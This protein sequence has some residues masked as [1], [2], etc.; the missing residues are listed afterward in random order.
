MTT[1]K[2]SALINACGWVFFLVAAPWLLYKTITISGSSQ[3]LWA[4][5]YTVVILAFWPIQT[6]YHLLINTGREAELLRRVDRGSMLFL[7]AAIFSPCMSS[8][9]ADPLATA[10]IILFWTGAIGGLIALITIKN[11]SRSLAPVLGFFIGIAGIVVLGFNAENIPYPGVSLLT[12]GTAFFLAGGLV[13]VLKKPDPNPK[14]FGFHEVFHTLLSIGI[15]FL[16]FLVVQA[17]T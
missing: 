8:F 16:H 15:L 4:V 11:L 13:Y 7:I 3:L 6:A 12:A 14:V 10:M 17:L 1:D 2:W 5:T 9:V